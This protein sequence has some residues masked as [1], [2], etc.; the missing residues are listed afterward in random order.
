M[1]CKQAEQL[2]IAS[3]DTTL[4][5]KIRTK[6]DIHVSGCAKCAGFQKDLAEILTH[7]HRLPARVPADLLS[8]PT[9]AQCHAELSR[10]NESVAQAGNDTMSETAS[11]WLLM[12]LIGLAVL[13]AIVAVPIVSDFLR[14]YSIPNYA[15]IGAIV[16]I[17]NVLML[18][19]AP[20]L[21][22][23]KILKELPDHGVL[24]GI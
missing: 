15:I 24:N 13:T 6:L 7:L 19:F 3:S 5:P 9:R 22:R 14:H 12:A 10:Q 20:V 16:L 21:L 1:R 17:Q 2:I 11:R 4:E 8:E 18:L 23:L